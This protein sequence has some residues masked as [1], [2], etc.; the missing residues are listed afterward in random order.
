MIILR[1]VRASNH[2]LYQAAGI[3]LAAARVRRLP[4]IVPNFL[5]T[6]LVSMAASDSASASQPQSPAILQQ[7]ASGS[8]FTKNHSKR[9][10]SL[11]V[12]GCL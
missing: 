2:E 9:R 4:A 7:S 6:D 1:A 12:T 8:L 10:S 3:Q 5:Y 11:M